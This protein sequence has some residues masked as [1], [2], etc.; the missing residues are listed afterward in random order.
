MTAKT[1][2]DAQIRDFHQEYLACEI[3]SVVS[4][5]K[6]KG[7]KHSAVW[8]GFRR[9]NLEIIPQEIT[10][11]K[12]PI[13]ESFFENIDTEERA[14]ILGLLYA[15][16]CNHE[17]HHKIEL[18]L[19]KIDEDIVIKV[20]KILL[21]GNVDI[22]EYPQKNNP[23]NRVCL[24][25]IN[26]KL[27][28]DL[29][30]WGCVARKTLVLKFPELP[31]NLRHHFIRG[32]FDGDGSLTIKERLMK[33]CKNKSRIAYFSI[34]STKEVLEEIGKTFSDLGV[35]FEINKRH[36]KRKNNNFTLR[37]SGNRQIKTV[38]DYLYNGANIFLDRKKDSYLE[39]TEMSKKFRKKY[40]YE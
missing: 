17:Q 12:F 19:D 1:Y 9:L 11:R 35:H 14:Y 22:K 6:T 13:N 7:L 2:S 10:R 28:D 15:D 16:G 18:S 20:S 24:Y 38:C 33:R 34:V 4:F 23:S 31:N 36:K 30:K 32:Y 39:L 27:S 8:G 26:Q 40:Q 37:I 29:K 5:A 25:L 3:L 21:N